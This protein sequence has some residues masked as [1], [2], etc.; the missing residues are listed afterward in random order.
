MVCIK[1]KNHVFFFLLNQHKTMS[2]DGGTDFEVRTNKK[3]KKPKKSVCCA[4]KISLFIDKFFFTFFF[5]VQRNL[6][7]LLLPLKQ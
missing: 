6:V 5:L 3:K 7:T 1:K 2:F 4:T